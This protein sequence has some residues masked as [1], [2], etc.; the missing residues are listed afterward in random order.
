MELPVEIVVLLLAL[1]PE[2]GREI[3]YS[4]DGRR[5]RNRLSNKVRYGREEVP[6]CGNVAGSGSRG[7]VTG[8][9]CDERYPDS[10]LIEVSLD[11]PEAGRGVEEL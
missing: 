10:A 1:V 7:D 8:P 4:V 11:A 5:L 2:K 6:E 3:G 9:S